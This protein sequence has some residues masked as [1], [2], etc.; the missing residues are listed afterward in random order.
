MLYRKF[1]RRLEEFLNNEP[2]KILLVNGARQIGKSYIIRYVGKQLFKNFV[3][4]NLKADKEGMG[5]F[6]SVRSVDDFYLQL[7]AIAG[8]KL[9]NKQDT[10]VFLDEI[11]SYP[12][13]MT[14]L[15][16][17][18]EEGKYRY[19]ASGSELGVALAQ[20]PSVPIGSI[21]I[22]QMYPLD[23]EEFLLAMGCGQ[24]TIDGVRRSF[25]NRQSLNDSM[26]NY[27]LQ[28]FKLYLLVGGMPDAIN[29]FLENRN[30][31]QVRNIQ[32]DIHT[33]YRID[34]SQYDE[35]KK[36]VIRNI[37]D[38]IPSNMENKKKRIIVKNIEGKSGHKQYSD[39]AEEFEYLTNSGVVL[40]VR[41]ISNPK[42]P[43]LESES[44]NL[45]KLYLSDVG[46]L[47]N[48]L[49]GTNVN[50]VLGDVLSINLGSVYESVV[51]QELHAHGFQ[52][53]YYD[54]KQRGEVDFLIDD[55]DSLTVLPIEVKSGK[56]YKV[57]SA[58]DRFIA[59]PDYHITRAVVLS[60][61]QK[62]YED[63]GII[64]MPVYYVM[65]FK[66]QAATDSDCIIPEIPTVP[67]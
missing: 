33:L 2:R 41:A 18:N 21:A 31:T 53:H 12:H 36:L 4:I 61:E 58:L 51:A 49:F 62:V 3:E 20:T 48:L 46:L 42:F 9:G 17:L 22:E 5:I 47:T 57:H 40:Q 10:I 34:A 23:F 67:E 38:L 39:Y 7:G 32:R 55:Y 30:I 64:Y 37:Y 11:Q 6:Q 1:A 35:E 60:N 29:K 54:N 59:T 28:Q 25:E 52:L 13:L 43:L 8:D 56:D 14:M 24:N 63:C 27:M 45:L 66:N 65:F 50:A 15:K 44:K 19:I 16:F 26:H